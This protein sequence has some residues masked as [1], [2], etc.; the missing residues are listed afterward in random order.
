MLLAC[1]NASTFIQLLDAKCLDNALPNFACAITQADDKK[2][3]F[4]FICIER[5]NCLEKNLQLPYALKVK[6]NNN[7]KALVAEI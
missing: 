4:A 1:Y 7:N 3:I 2:K 6:K 5:E